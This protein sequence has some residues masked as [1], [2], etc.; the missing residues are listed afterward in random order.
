MRIAPYLQLR[1]PVVRRVLLVIGMFCMWAAAV[2]AWPHHVDARSQATEAAAARSQY[3][4]KVA[5]TYSDKYAAGQHFLP[6]NMTTDTGEFLDPGR[7]PTAEYCG[8]CHQDSYRQWRESAHS[9]ANRAPW[10][11]RN[12]ALLR[13]QRGVEAMRHCEGC[14]DPVALAAGDLTPSAPNQRHSY[15]E[16]GVTCMVCHSVQRVDTRGTGSYVFGVP[17]VLMDEQGNPVT[18]PVSD[19]EILAHLD[20]HSA[21]VMKPFYKSSEYCASCHKAALPRE[22]TEYKWQRAISL[23]DEWQNSSFARQSPLPFYTK[24]QTSTC[25]TCHMQRE[26]LT[27][28]DA[29]AKDGMLA[30]HRWLGANTTVPQYYRYPQQMQRI[31][32]YLQAGVLSVDIFGIEHGNGLSATPLTTISAPLASTAFHVGAG[33]L[34]TADVVIQNTGIAHS[35]VPEQRDMYEAWVEFSLSDAHGRVL[36]RSGFI[37]SRS[38]A[39]DPRAQSFTNRLVNTSSTVNREH[40][41]WD[42]RV[43]AF[44]NTIQSGRSQLVRYTFHMPGAHSGPLTMT[45]CVK[46][47]RFNQHFIDFGMDM[48]AG[49][50]YPQ[51]VVTMASASAKIRVGS[52][53]PS[54]AVAGA[55]PEWKR[56]NNYAIALLD[57]RQYDTAV[58]AFSKV[59]QLRPEYADAYTNRA[60]AELQWQKYTEALQDLSQSLRLAKE[61]SRALYYRGV[62]RRSVGDLKG[63]VADLQRVMEAFP[64]S[65]DAHRELGF[66][67]MQ[68]HRYAEAQVQ[69]E[70]VQGID[71]DDLSAYYNLAILYRRLGM[72][73]KAAQQAARFEDE[74]D[75]PSASVYALAYLRSHS[76]VANETI[77]WHTHDLDAPADHNTGALPTLFS[78][79]EQ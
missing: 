31:I 33:E 1:C 51:V 39:L 57:A 12:V 73:D 44:N 64:R 63:A 61:D 62:A 48:P 25:Q 60:I 72:P 9:N 23:Y 76:E 67:L 49:K 74:K 41:V 54:P 75:D 58:D 16:D 17:A 52:N 47:R 65:R 55:E 3:S 68:M 45:A 36:R 46:Y 32:E 6:S 50:H 13:S 22:L 71:P 15:D 2:I 8:H 79:T 10:Y 27:Q 29:G 28:A 30:S 34:V 11:L 66:T 4:E 14:H 77:A 18:R 26:K 56:W 43:V 69:Y 24:A 78:G 5:R 38:R 7:V 53:L 19:G 35:L 40:Q 37:D 59:V 20:R 21:A 70:A 42:T